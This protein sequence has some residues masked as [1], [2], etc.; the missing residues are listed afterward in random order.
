MGKID[1]ESPVPAYYQI[2]LDIQG[3]IA[4]QEWKA[5]ENIPSETALAKQY[6]VS[7]VTMR[8]AL[9]ELAKD[10]ILERR[11]GSGTFISQKPIPLVHDQSLPHIMAGRLHSRGLVTSSQIVET[12]TFPGPTPQVQE[13]LRVTPSTS[14]AYLKRIL[15]IGDQPAALNRSWFDHSLCPGIT[16]QRLVDESLS[17]TLRERYGLVPA[18]AD[19]WLEAV[20]GTRETLALLELDGGLDTPMILL[21]SVSYL[22]DGTPLE[23]SITEWLGD[24]I[25]F[26]FRSPF[27]HESTDQRYGMRIGL[28]SDSVPMPED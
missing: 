22:A 5:G 16:E 23:Y 26:N 12:H 1:R 25:R 19:N 4:Q 15:L 6:G 7:R 13:S 28:T 24:R 18:Y 20:R 10:G 2:A 3:R 9:A 11:Q 14:I 17:K 21:Q 8:Q 27:A